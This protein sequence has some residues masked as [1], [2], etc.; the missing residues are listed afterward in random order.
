L[1]RDQ[2]FFKALFYSGDHAADLGQVK[3][4]EIARFPDDTG[5]LFNHVWGKTLRDGSQ[6]IFGMRRHPNPT[7]CPVRAIEL[8]VAIA[9]ELSVD[10]STGYLF[11]PTNLQGHILNQPW[12]SFSASARLKVY[13]SRCTSDRLTLIL[14]KH[15][16][17]SG[18]V[19]L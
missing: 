9:K 3:T 15:F 5:L 10:L 14:G 6:N 13:L 4:A 1:A 8:Y 11:R 19:A 7:L 16:T 2:A 18:L 12:S 17:V